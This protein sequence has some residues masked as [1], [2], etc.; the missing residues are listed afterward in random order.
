VPVYIGETIRASATVTKV[1]ARRALADLACEV[2]NQDGVI[3]LRG[4]ATVLQV[5]PEGG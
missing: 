5:A 4:H 1:N 2:T 3:V